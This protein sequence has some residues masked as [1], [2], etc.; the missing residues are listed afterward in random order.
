M[1]TRLVRAPRIDFASLR[2][3]LELPT[4]FPLAAQR[5]ADEV[6]ARVT[7]GLTA[8]VAST[9]VVDRTD[10]P[11]VT[12]DPATSRDLDQALSL[13]R[14]E[15][16]FRVFYA[17]ADVTAFVPLGGDLESETWLRGETIYLP[18]GKVP[19]H[20]VSMSE[21]AASLLPGET[22]PAVLWTIDLDSDGATNAV[23]VE[24][25]VVRSRAKLDYVGVQ[26]AAAAGVLEDPVALLP[27]IGSLLHARGLDRGAINLPIPE[28]ELEPDDGGWRLT[29]RAPIPAE[30]WNA[31]I[32]LLTGMCAADIML[33]ERV[34]LLRTMPSPRPEAV[35]AL[36]SVAAGL[37]VDWAHG[38]PIGRLLTSIDPANPRGA[39]LV[40]QA[41]E[42]L[43]GAGYIVLDGATPEQTGHGG[44]GAPYAHVTAP[45]RRLADRYATEVC[46]SLA[47]GR[48]V[49]DWVRAALPQLP[50]V[51]EKS[52]RRASAAE[53][54]AIELAEAVTLQHRVGEEFDAVV[55]D[56][57]PAR[58]NA[59]GGARPATAVI[60][61]DDPPVRA[62][63]EGA[64][65]MGERVRARLVQADPA[66]CT[67]LFALSPTPSS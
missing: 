38:V 8:E 33:A 58:T 31:Q 57:A 37:G 11:F 65:T 47:E 55:L 28:Q 66:R 41:A 46:L 17:I 53:R 48:D 51:M 56:A 54:G 42:L 43:R 15:G 44:V 21:G 39:A 61:I 9:A 22:R 64:A 6:A 60:A 3:E 25:A 49:P 18:D 27:E 63:C 62:R 4:R 29:L 36:R 2:R 24:R 13:H 67:V 10:I 14:R 1:V 30:D 7:A 26:E 16:G 5:E 20:P 40:D 23:R 32:S 45:L 52:G 12:I 35:A 34:G 50:E 59:N 19:L